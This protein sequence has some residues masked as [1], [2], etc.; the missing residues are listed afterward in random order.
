MNP[1]E[2]TRPP[3]GRRVRDRMIDRDGTAN[4]ALARDRAIRN[5]LLLFDDDLREAA[6]ALGGLES[7]LSRTLTTLESDRLTRADVEALA[8]EKAVEE[9]LGQLDDGIANLRRR[10]RQ[11]A[12][13]LR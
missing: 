4:P 3:E 11:I 7:F 1:A 6:L 2:I 12:Q 5:H 9:Q 8:T 13:S 10:L